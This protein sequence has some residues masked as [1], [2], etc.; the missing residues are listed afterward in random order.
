MNSYTCSVVLI[1]LFLLFRSSCH[2]SPDYSGEEDIALADEPDEEDIADGSSCYGVTSDD[3]DE[4][5]MAETFEET[6]NVIH[7]VEGGTAGG[8]DF[9]EDEQ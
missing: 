6:T 1:I 8:S 9:R 2:Q 4:E 7:T 3:S 5:D